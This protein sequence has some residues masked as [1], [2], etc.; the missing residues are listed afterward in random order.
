MIV[1]VGKDEIDITVAIGVPA[2]DGLDAA[3]GGN[4]GVGAAVAECA[5]SEILERIF[6]PLRSLGT[7]DQA[8]TNESNQ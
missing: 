5:V 4:V 8:N 7:G 2:V 1:R 6:N 3:F